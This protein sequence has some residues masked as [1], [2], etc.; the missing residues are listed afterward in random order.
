MLLLT[1]YQSDEAVLPVET[2]FSAV[3]CFDGLAAVPFEEA[4][5]ESESALLAG[6]SL[7][8]VSYQPVPFN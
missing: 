4:P 8:S 6:L 2:G 7:K 3:V 1:A 5:L